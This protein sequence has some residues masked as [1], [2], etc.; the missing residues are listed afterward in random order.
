MKVN[1]TTSSATEAPETHEFDFTEDGESIAIQAL[2]EAGTIVVGALLEA[3][4]VLVIGHGFSAG[5]DSLGALPH[6]RGAQ[7]DLIAHSLAAGIKQLLSEVG[8]K[9]MRKLISEDTAGLL[10]V[11][12]ITHGLYSETYTVES[13]EEIRRYLRE[14]VSVG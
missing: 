2:D 12:L 4:D 13:D 3:G 5:I 8:E 9:R 1:I 7:A 14:E 6:S 11:A 10:S